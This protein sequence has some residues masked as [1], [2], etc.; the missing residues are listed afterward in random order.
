MRESETGRTCRRRRRVAVCRRSVIGSCT[1]NGSEKIK[2]RY[3]ISKL[4]D[5]FLFIVRRRR[6]SS[7][8]QFLRDRALRYSI[9]RITISS[10]CT[11]QVAREKRVAKITVQMRVGK[12]RAK[13]RE[14][15]F[16][17]FRLPLFL[18]R[19]D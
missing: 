16:F 14:M 19:K 15:P 1:H 4:G 13:K 5:N 3:R 2:T 18:P 7:I 11:Y 8:V 17:F 6:F 9:A 10:F 12:K